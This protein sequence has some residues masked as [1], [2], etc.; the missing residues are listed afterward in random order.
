MISSYNAS[1][2]T[3]DEELRINKSDRSNY[4]SF[5]K[6][7][8]TFNVDFDEKNLLA[9]RDGFK[10]PL[11]YIEEMQLDFFN[12]YLWSKFSNAEYEKSGLGFTNKYEIILR[13]ILKYFEGLPKDYP[14]DILLIGDFL[15]VLG[16][17]NVLNF[18]TFK[19]EGL[20]LSWKGL[21]PDPHSRV[22]RNYYNPELKRNNDSFL[23]RTIGN[24]FPSYDSGV[25]R[26]W[27]CGSDGSGLLVSEN[28][29]WINEKKS[30]LIVGSLENKT[31]LDMNIDVIKL[32]Y[33]LCLSSVAACK[34]N[35]I[36]CIKIHLPINN[37]LYGIYSLFSLFFHK[38]RLIKL[39][40]QPADD[41]SCYLIGIY[42]IP[43]EKDELQILLEPEA[44]QKVLTVF[45][46]ETINLSEFMDK[47]LT[48][49]LSKWMQSIRKKWDLRTADQLI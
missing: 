33:K 3:L 26:K 22:S 41:L 37:G 34:Q 49:E 13:L 36:C 1:E 27:Y 19:Y 4:I 7:L 12:P 10:P 30:I 46:K 39:K 29:T 42:N 8:K 38:T 23:E 20:V 5:I 40:H 15:E 43:L 17:S 31:H 44:M 45:A 24:S 47:R 32:Y 18:P 21:V 11:T 28:I 9:T 35:G 6:N 48:P 14:V 16:F 2:I 25:G